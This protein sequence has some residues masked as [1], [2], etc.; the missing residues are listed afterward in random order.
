MVERALTFD[1]RR[2]GFASRL[3]ASATYET[4]FG[5]LQAGKESKPLERSAAIV[6]GAGDARI[7][8]T[9]AVEVA[10][11]VMYNVA[12][13]IEWRVRPSYHSPRLAAAHFTKPTLAEAIENLRGSPSFW[14]RMP[15]QRN[16]AW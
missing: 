11:K 5:Y 16:A 3:S 15:S 9:K 2:K 8:A 10:I 13:S 4:H 12:S 7:G 1:F 14:G 6:V